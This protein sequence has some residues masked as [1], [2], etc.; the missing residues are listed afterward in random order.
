MPSKRSRLL[1]WAIVIIAMILLS[2]TATIAFGMGREPEP[3]PMQSG[4]QDTGKSGLTVRPEG[5]GD[6]PSKA[7]GSTLQP[8]GSAE[9]GAS[10]SIGS[11]LTSSVDAQNS[12]MGQA[13]VTLQAGNAANSLQADLNLPDD[14]LQRV[15][16]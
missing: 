11:G 14:T 9:A 15:I 1:F 8:Q 16:P 10:N 6:T 5:L 7:A 3:T 12:L 2:I 4:G 13:P